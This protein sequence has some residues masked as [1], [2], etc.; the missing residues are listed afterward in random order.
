M[1]V[2]DKKR[3][4]YVRIPKTAST[5]VSAALEPYRRKADRSLIGRIG[6][7]VAPKST[8]PALTD[9]R[10]HSH[11]GL[12]AAREVLG[13]DR[14]NSMYRFSVVRHPV[15][16][17]RSLYAHIMRYQSD[18]EFQRAFGGIYEAYADADCNSLDHFI[19]WLER[20]PIPAQAALLIDYRGN[21]LANAVA[22][23]E[24]L[25]V[26]VGQILGRL[27]IDANVPRLNVGDDRSRAKV[28]EASLAKIREL[29]AVDY[30]LFGYEDDVTA[31]V[32]R[33]TARQS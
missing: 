13:E 4:I 15:S 21:I 6:R 24:N 18:P 3:F 22:R 29:Y 28:S 2:S 9:F 31:A 26:E 14:F 10:A 8:H 30:E 7:R 27:G 33:E 17:T 11:W 16:R 5:S 25:D 19:E 23:V 12:Q 20:N 1:I 32:F